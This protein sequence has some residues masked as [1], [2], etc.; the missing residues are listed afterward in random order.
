MLGIEGRKL[1]LWVAT[2]ALLGTSGTG[3]ARRVHVH[4]HDPVV[5]LEKEHEDKTIV[6]VNE[7]PAPRRK[8]WKHRK[9]WHCRVR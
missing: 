1:G 2:L 5:V 9:H 3:C 6:I 7:R 4:H 8:C